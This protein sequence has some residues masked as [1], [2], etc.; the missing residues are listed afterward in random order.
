MAP[1]K[2]VVP[3]KQHEPRNWWPI[4]ALIA[5]GTVATLIS[6]NIEAILKLYKTLCG[7]HPAP[8]SVEKIEPCSKKGMQG[9][10]ECH[11]Q[12]DNTGSMVSY[13]Y[14][15]PEGRQLWRDGK[16][17]VGDVVLNFDNRTLVVTFGG[18]PINGTISGQ[19]CD[20]ISFGSTT[21][22]KIPQT[23]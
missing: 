18:A 5:A 22:T 16:K 11:G 15:R 21:A 7:F 10:W 23:P 4:A 2:T 20:S 9:P 13:L 19:F 6:T 3:P 12:C 1:R 14:E 8:M 17:R